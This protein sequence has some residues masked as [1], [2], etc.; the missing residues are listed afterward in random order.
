MRDDPHLV[1]ALHW[2]VT[3]GDRPQ[4]FEA[5]MRSARGL[6]RPGTAEAHHA[7]RQ[8]LAG[9]ACIHQTGQ[10]IV[11]AERSGW[12]LAYALSWIAVAGGDSVMAPWVRHQFPETGV[13]VRRLRDTSCNDPACAWCREWSDPAKLLNQWF[14][15]ASFRTKPADKDGRSLQETIAAAALARS[16]VLGILPTGTGKSLCFQ[17]PALAAY[18]RTGGLTVVISPLVA[19]MADQVANLHRQGIAS[20]VTVNGLLSLPE[21][22]NALDRLRLGDASMLLISPEQLR[23]PSVRSILEQRDV[24]YWV[25]DEAHCVSKWGHDFRPDYRYI[26]RFIREYTGNSEP[27]PLI[28]LTAT[29]KPGVIDDIC[30]YFEGELGV[31]I[32]RIDGG[33]RRDNLSFEVVRTDKTGKLGDIIAVLEDALPAEGASGAIIYCATRSATERVADVLREKGYAARH[34]HAGLKPESRL[35]AQGRFASGAL[36]IIAATNAFGMGIDKPDIRLVVHADIP[37]SLE[38]YVQ[39]AGRAGGPARCVLLYSKDDIEKQFMLQARARLDKQGIAAILKALRRLGRRSKLEGEVVATPGEIARE[40]VDGDFGRDQA[41]EDTRIKTAV[42]WLEDAALLKREENVVRLFPSTLKIRTMEE[43]RQRIEASGATAGY[44]AKLLRLIRSLLDSPPDRGIS[45]DELCGESGFAPARLRKAL[46]VLEALG[47]TS[48][49]TAITVFIHVGVED[50]SRQRLVEMSGLESTLIDQLRELAPDLESGAISTLDLRLASQRLRDA[51]HAT[52][53]PDIVERLLRG[54]ARDGRED[55]EGVGSL[56]VRK[57]D[58]HRLRLRL[59]RSWDGLTLTS[60]LRR[61]AADV[62]FTS[63]AGSAPAGAR[64][65]DVQVVTT[66]GVLISALASDLELSR[67]INDPSALLDHALLWLHEQNVITLGRGLTIFR[68]AITVRLKAGNRKFTETDFQ[69][70]HIHHEEQT[71]Q[72][73]IIAAYAERGL[74]SIGDAL[75]LMEDY[76]THNRQAFVDKWLPRSAAA[77]RRQTTP[78]SWRTIIE[79]LANPRQARIVSDDREQTSVLVLAGPGSGKTRVPPGLFGDIAPPQDCWH[80]A[81]LGGDID[82]RAVGLLGDIDRPCGWRAGDG[83]GEEALQSVGG[84]V[85]NAVLLAEAEA[86]EGVDAPLAHEG[87]D[88]NGGNAGFLC[89]QMAECL[90]VFGDAE[91]RDVGIDEIGALTGQDRKSGPRKAAGQ[92]IALALESGREIRVIGRLLFQPVGHGL[93]QVGSCREG[94][95]LV[96]LHD[97]SHESGRPLDP[98]DLPSRQREDLAGRGNPQGSLTHAVK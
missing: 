93:L 97:G 1:A 32:E 56:H 62:L 38:N 25:V 29:A 49:D 75:L 42:S 81:D 72:T 50:S 11:E 14:G 23:N 52:I 33:A 9:R 30:A 10:A 67:E 76:F 82:H 15:F 2:L 21:R 28:C 18:H 31:G 40:D 63:L 65:K 58:R 27:A 83:S 12:S 36:R 64:G 78:E 13:I 91:G 89:D 68:P 8:V 79:S 6:S 55:A 16:S 45:T 86:D 24:A 73:H 87:A 88:R 70:L 92:A 71:L 3:S 26:A 43:A 34:Y 69:P 53:R 85:E 46:N 37:A 51:D 98:S 7:I 96:R 66:L 59:Q 17:L 47:I 22:H 19:L 60:R 95:K 90:V 77:L 48:N 39:E 80:P 61:R 44:R 4:G 54:I 41:T 20:C 35:E 5:V 74:G 57:I 94:D 84:G